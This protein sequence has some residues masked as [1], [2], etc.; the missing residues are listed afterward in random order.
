MHSLSPNP[1]PST[2]LQPLSGLTQSSQSQRAEMCTA[3]AGT[4]LHPAAAVCSACRSCDTSVPRG[5]REVLTYLEIVQ[6]MH[7]QRKCVFKE[8]CQCSVRC[9]QCAASVHET[10]TETPRGE[11]MCANSGRIYV[12]RQDVCKQRTVASSVCKQRTVASSAGMLSPLA[13]SHGSQKNR[14]LT[15]HRS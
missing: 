6:E 8:L 4:V 15:T 14:S 10:A 9:A 12:T 13:R 1:V 5:T 7:R 2:G 3:C 11:R